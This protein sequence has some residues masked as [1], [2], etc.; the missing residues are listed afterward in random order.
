MVDAVTRERR[1]YLADRLNDA[2]CVLRCVSII[3][4]E[5]ALRRHGVEPDEERGTGTFDGRLLDEVMEAAAAL[6]EG[7]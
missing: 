3:E 2:W 6:R 7:K 5:H 1:E 4:G